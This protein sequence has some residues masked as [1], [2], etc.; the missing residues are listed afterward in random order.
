MKKENLNLIGKKANSVATT[1]LYVES[2]GFTAN[3]Y[4]RTFWKSSGA[5]NGFR[6]VGT[7]YGC[8]SMSAV[9]LIKVDSKYTNGYTLID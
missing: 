1:W 4:T 2:D 9:E 8:N 7:V 3:V 6:Y 5:D